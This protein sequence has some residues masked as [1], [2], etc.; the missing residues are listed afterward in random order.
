MSEAKFE[1]WRNRV[2]ALCWQVWGRGGFEHVLPGVWTEWYKSPVRK[3]LTDWEFA[4]L[5]AM[6]FAAHASVTDAGR[7]LS[8]LAFC[9]EKAVRDRQRDNARQTEY[10]KAAFGK[11]Q[12]I[13][14]TG[15]P[16]AAPAEIPEP[17]DVGNLEQPPR[18]VP[19]GH[20]LVYGHVGPVPAAPAKL[21]PK[22]ILNWVEEVTDAL[23][24]QKLFPTV[25][26]LISML[27]HLP[28][29]DADDRTR[30]A[31]LVEALLYRESEQ[32]LFRLREMVR[33]AALPVAPKPAAA[34]PK[35]AKPKP[36]AEARNPLAEV[37]TDPAGAKKYTVLGHPV[38]AVLRWMGKDAW[39]FTEARAC[40]KALGLPDVSDNTVKAQLLTGRKGDGYAGRKPAAQ[41]T[42]AQADTLYDLLE[43]A[44]A[45][46]AEQQAAEEHGPDPRQAERPRGGGRAEGAAHQ[47]RRKAQAPAVPAAEGRGERRPDRKPPAPVRPPD[48][49][50]R[51]RG[52]AGGATPGPGGGPGRVG[53]RGA[54]TADDVRH[55]GGGAAPREAGAGSRGP[56]GGNRVKPPP[57]RKDGPR[58][59]RKQP[60]GGGKPAPGRVKPA[61]RK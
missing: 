12:T 61:K 26:C 60:P 40:L 32:E 4:V 37:T 22:G 6:P 25:Q 33:R 38:T 21:T 35:P 10:M 36:V 49:P 34:A 57:A 2:S 5:V 52:G 45:P 29:L 48:Q 14:K 42:P 31:G 51:V 1:K 39:S 59:P 47:D 58:K 50:A 44:G 15:G 53:G 20:R 16:K 17:P 28:G 7:R 56:V 27:T 11:A 19:K 23:A 18:E 24:D 54:K 3:Q 55:G 9:T 8:P 13:A 41:L 43:T 46:A 30:A